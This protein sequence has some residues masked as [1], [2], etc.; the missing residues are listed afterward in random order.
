MEERTISDTNRCPTCGEPGSAD[1]APTEKRRRVGG[2]R[3]P[4]RVVKR[5]RTWGR[6]ILGVLDE[7]V[8]GIVYL[9]EQHEPIH[10]PVAL[11]LMLRATP[12]RAPELR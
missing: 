11:K 7:G 4:T 3:A 9:A 5:R 2:P 1:E 10:R 6:T 12:G 8:M